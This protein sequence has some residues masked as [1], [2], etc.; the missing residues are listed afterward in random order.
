M[1]WSEK[2]GKIATFRVDRIYQIPEMLS[3]KAIPKPRQYTIG[4]F[5]E[6][7]FQLFDKEHAMVE[8]LCENGAM[9]TVIDHF[10]TKI[11]TEQIDS[12]HFSFKAEVAVSPVFFAW[13]FEFGGMIRI[14][15]PQ[16][17]KNAYQQRL[18]RQ[19]EI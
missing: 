7:A 15:A 10:G 19:L 11:H 2:H 8:L 14:I 18:K 3:E 6:K 9:N 5:A 16:E 4:D 13:V 17:I 12:E 1:G